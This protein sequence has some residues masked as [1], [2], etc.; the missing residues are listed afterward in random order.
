MLTLLC[1]DL[2]THVGNG[3]AIT[4]GDIVEPSITTERL[5]HY[6]SL[7]PATGSTIRNLAALKPRVLAT[8]HGSSFSGDG[9]AAL[10]ALAD[11]YDML[12]RKALADSK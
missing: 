10:R 5:F 7:G 3:P 1:G 8:M 4:E 2:F 9:A 12:L 6:T 11:H